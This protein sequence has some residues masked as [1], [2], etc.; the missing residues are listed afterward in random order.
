[1]ETAQ[2]FSPV[3]GS[4]ERQKHEQND[5]WSYTAPVTATMERKRG[6]MTLNL[7]QPCCLPDNDDD[8]LTREQKV[9][10][11][12]QQSKHNTVCY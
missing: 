12:S 8:E 3:E 7:P 5:H 4:R 11:I 10:R 1:M 6:G 9:L 2:Y